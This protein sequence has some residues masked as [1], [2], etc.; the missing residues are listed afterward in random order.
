MDLAAG[1]RRVIVMMTHVTDKGE[2][3]LVQ[4]LSY[5]PTALGVVSKVF[6]DL[7]VVSVTEKG[8]HLDEIVNGLC[9][10][11]LQQVTGA[12]LHWDTPPATIRV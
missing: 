2:P 10:Q 11:E 6:T 1:A 9:P 3:K 8:F 5:P 4:R 7:A 12:P